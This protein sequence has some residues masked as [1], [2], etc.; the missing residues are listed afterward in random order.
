M[1]A[2]RS[3]KSGAPREH[4]RQAFA[5]PPRTASAVARCPPPNDPQP[6]ASKI[7]ANGWCTAKFRPKSTRIFDCTSSALLRPGLVIK[8]TIAACPRRAPCLRRALKPSLSTR[9]QVQIA[10]ER[11]SRRCQPTLRR[12]GR[13]RSRRGHRL[14]RGLRER[15]VEPCAVLWQIERH[16]PLLAS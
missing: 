8:K 9:R 5:C 6:T 10:N 1:I 15:R 11:L 16:G 14:G 2:V 7:R 3:R 4:L 12:K 13:Q